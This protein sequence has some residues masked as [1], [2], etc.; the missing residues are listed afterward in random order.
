LDIFYFSLSIYLGLR[1]SY[2]GLAG[3]FAASPCGKRP[4]FRQSRNYFGGYASRGEASLFCKAR[5]ESRRAFHMEGGKAAD[6]EV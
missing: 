3:G 4:A 1:G 6:A 5:T 2:F